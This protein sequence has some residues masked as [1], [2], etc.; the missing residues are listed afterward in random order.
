[1]CLLF[2][3]VWTIAVQSEVW[4]DDH[5]EEVGDACPKCRVPVVDGVQYRGNDFG[6]A[7]FGEGIISSNSRNV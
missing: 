3:C 1:M 5:R 6:G 4:R 2:A 7:G